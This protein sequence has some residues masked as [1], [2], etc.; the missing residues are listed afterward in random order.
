MDKKKIYPYRRQHKNY[1]TDLNVF[2]MVPVHNPAINGNK[3]TS[4][5]SRENSP[6][7]NGFVFMHIN[8]THIINIIIANII[9]NL[10][11]L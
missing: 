6:K 5:K 9:S 3:C 10:W 8:S 2:K 7:E 11:V 1:E 4:Y